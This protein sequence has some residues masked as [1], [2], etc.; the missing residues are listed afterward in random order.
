MCVC[1]RERDLQV[2]DVNSGGEKVAREPPEE[3][4]QPLVRNL[5]RG[6]RLRALRETG[7]YEPFEETTGYEPFERQQYPPEE[8]GPRLVRNLQVQ[9]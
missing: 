4:G 5:A 9:V 1:E 3:D 8:D 6:N 7:G 2:V